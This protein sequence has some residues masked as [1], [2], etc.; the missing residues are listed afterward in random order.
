MSG[1]LR[2]LPAHSP[3]P[4]DHVDLLFGEHCLRL[5]DPRRFGA[6]LWA[7]GDPLAHPPAQTGTRTAVGR[8]LRHSSAACGGTTAERS[9]TDHGRIRRRRRRQYLRVQRRCSTPDPPAGPVPA[10]FPPP[11]WTPLRTRSRWC[12]RAIERGGTTLRDFVNESGEPGYFPGTVRL[13]ACRRTL[14][15]LRDTDPDPADRPARQR[16]LPGCQH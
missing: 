15:M 4:H 1:S 10:D 14:P 9:T 12:W 3:R 16:L 13:R 6:M 11:A 5:H 8:L 7:E 2:V